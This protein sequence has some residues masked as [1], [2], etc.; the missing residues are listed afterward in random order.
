MSEHEKVQTL[1]NVISDLTTLLNN[2]NEG[3]PDEDWWLDAKL[4]VEYIY[5]E[6]PHL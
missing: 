2:I 3:N 4:A 1:K 6:Q 5:E